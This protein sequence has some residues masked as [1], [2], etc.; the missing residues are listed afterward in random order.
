MLTTNPN[1][2]RGKK[3]HNVVRRRLTYLHANLGQIDFHSK[4]LPGIDVGIMRFLKGSFQF[5]KL[6]GGKCSA[7]TTMFFL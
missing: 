7:I 4:L 6:V 2:F 5:M 3:H 1:G